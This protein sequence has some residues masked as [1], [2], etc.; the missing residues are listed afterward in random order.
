MSKQVSTKYEFSFPVAGQASPCYFDVRCL[1]CKGVPVTFDNTLMNPNV[2]TH[3]D[4]LLDY[5]SD[6]SDA[7]KRNMY[8]H[9]RDYLLWAE[10]NHQAPF[11]QEAIDGFN[12]ASDNIARKR[13]LNRFH[14]IIGMDPPSVLAPGSKPRKKS[15][16]KSKAPNPRTYPV[17]PTS[18]HPIE[19]RDCFVFTVDGDHKIIVNSRTTGLTQLSLRADIQHLS[20]RYQL[21]SSLKEVFDECSGDTFLSKVGKIKDFIRCTKHQFFSV[22]TLSDYVEKQHQAVLL[23]KPG[24]THGR[25]K[26]SAVVEL[27]DIA[28]IHIPTS[29]RKRISKLPNPRSV[30][31]QSYEQKAYKKL[32]KFL[33]DI[34]KQS[35]QKLIERVYTGP[36]TVSGETIE[37]LGFTDVM[38]MFMS[39]SYY[40][41]ARYSAWT[42]GTIKGLLKSD[43][44]FESKDGEWIHLKAIKPR[45]NYKALE[46]TLYNGPPNGNAIRKTGYRILQDILRV[47]ESF[48]IQSEKLLFTVKEDGK[49]FP[50]RLQGRLRDSILR[51]IPE[52]GSLSSQRIRETEIAISHQKGFQAAALRAGSTKHV[53]KRHYSDGFREDANQQITQVSNA[54]YDVAQSG[55][56]HES[57]DSIKKRLYDTYRIPILTD[58]KPNTPM[59]TRCSSTQTD[60][61]FST[62]AA[63]R[64]L[65]NLSCADLTSCFGCKHA[66]IIDSA[67]DIWNLLSFKNQ[68]KEGRLFSLNTTHHDKNFAETIAKIDLA[69]EQC[70]ASNVAAAE[71][72]YQNDGPHPFWAGDE[73]L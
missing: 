14:R 73:F 64:N 9:F 46:L 2:E 28:E 45:A 52:L 33:L 18:Y 57:P 5:I 31:V 60:N 36:I 58:T 41:I 16:S 29:L 48:G 24:A 37:C 15:N 25:R 1:M 44:E 56:A 53:V 21:L 7:A 69:I 12:K 10:Q 4:D 26:A 3:I 11:T 65:G 70:S 67:D 8:N 42:D 59:G 39:A 27:F 43:I 38:S 20:D 55:V 40:L 35:H 30:P 50:L 61:A 63:N 47:T 54:I 71:N 72:K 19:D 32:V 62:K 13:A 66:A 68:L 6:R 34:Q 49:V 23:K 17:E 51:F 22:D